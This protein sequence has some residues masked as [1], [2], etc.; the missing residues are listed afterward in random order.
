MTEEIISRL[1]ASEIKRIDLSV[2]IHTI[3]DE[4]YDPQNI[5]RRV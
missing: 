5:S 1:G 3:F 4:E 2:I